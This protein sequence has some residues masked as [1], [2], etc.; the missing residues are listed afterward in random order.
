MKLSFTSISIDRVSV[1]EREQKEEESP[2]TPS[3]F[4]LMTV[5]QSPAP[6]SD[7]RLSAAFGGARARL[8]FFFKKNS[9]LLFLFF[10]RLGFLSMVFL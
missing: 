10:P 5:F 8:G 4:R 3:W 2:G 6:D 9:L 1:D 7:A